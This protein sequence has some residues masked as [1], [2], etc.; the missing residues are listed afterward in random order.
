MASK[1]NKLSELEDVLCNI[2]M[3]HRGVLNFFCNFKIGRILKPFDKVKSKGFKMSNLVVTLC[4][5]RIKG[6]TI[7][8]MQKLGN[9]E[10]FEGDE[11][12]FYRL[13]NNPRIKW[14]EILM[15][16][17]RQFVAITQNNCDSTNHEVKCF[18]IDD[19]DLIKTGHTFEFIGRI[20]N[21]VIGKSLFG[22]KLL[23]LGYWDGKSLI[24]TDFSLH[25]EK[26]KKGNYGI[27]KKEKMSQF[28]KKRDEKAVSCNRIEELDLKKTEVAASMIK[29]AVKNGL[30]ATYVLMDS[31]FTNDT[32]IKAVRT[33]DDG[34]M[35]VLGMCRIDKRKYKVYGKELN[36]HQIITR[37]ERKYSKYSRKH[38]SQYIPVVAD[39]KGTK[40]KLFFIRYRNAKD[41]TLLLTT[42]LELSFVQSLE[43]YQIRWT[44]EVL[45]KEC[46]Q[47]LRL[48]TCQNTDFDGQIAD[49]TLVFITHTI[50][51]L[52]RR[53]DAYETMGDL[54]REAQQ[55][56]LELTLWQRILNVFLKMLKQLLDIFNMD[57]DETMKRV[58]QNKKSYNQL[59]EIMKA[60]DKKENI[61]FFDK[62]AA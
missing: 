15:G 3:T 8:A 9:N 26:G 27:S 17:S 49:A 48:G 18:I 11:N 1:L 54:F 61:D 40:V 59:I 39:Y 62:I 41:W 20:F 25:R 55:N 53:F 31:W 36:A 60:L 30:K 29:R 51:T 58:L 43:L 7:W 33:I 44:I 10:L 5:Y 28:K 47:Y 46:K 16:F 42:N 22:F 19:T 56:L 50:L 24:A 38:K 45:F 14:R 57:I 2:E 6:F 12:C 13:M 4:L 52:Q 32:I 21:H 37:M 23:A 34:A 35:H